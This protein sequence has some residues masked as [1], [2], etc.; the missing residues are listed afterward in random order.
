MPSHL[1]HPTGA[2]TLALPTE[3]AVTSPLPNTVAIAVFDEVHVTMAP[4]IVA[5][6]W[7]LTVAVSCCVSPKE[8]KLRLVAESVIEVA[9]GVGVV[10]GAVVLSPP[11]APSNSTAVSRM[12]LML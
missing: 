10:G 7:S 5:P 3:I 6:F 1:L 11:H 12:Y 4:L 2:K 9:T 8:A